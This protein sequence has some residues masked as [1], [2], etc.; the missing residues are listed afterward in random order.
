MSLNECLIKN[1]DSVILSCWVKIGKEYP[2]VY[3]EY[4]D[5]AEE[6]WIRFRRMNHR[7]F[8]KIEN[9]CIVEVVGHNERDK[10]Y[11][12]DTVKLKEY[13]LRHMVIDW[14]F[15]TPLVFDQY[16]Y[17]TEESYQSLLN[18]HPRILRAIMSK[19][20]YRLDLTKEEEGKL[21][22]DCYV[23]FEKGNS[24]SNA[25]E[26]LS[27]YLELSSFWEKFGMNYN[28]VLD[29]PHEV[30]EG[31]KKIMSAENKSMSAKKD[32]PKSSGHSLKRGGTT[33]TFGF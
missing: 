7:E 30:Y 6:I 8:F 32:S 19:Y 21:E 14:C 17:L 5:G 11:V 9:S 29:L 31:L 27:L 18:L 20:R 22:R 28:D 4:T 26:Y 33:Q 15:D 23:I 10:T 25:N 13:I 12:Y 2:D 1:N 24:I 3:D 16:G